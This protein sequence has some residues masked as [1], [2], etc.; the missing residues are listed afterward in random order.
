MEALYGDSNVEKKLGP[1]KVLEDQYNLDFTC[2]NRSSGPVKVQK[3]SQCLRHPATVL[4][5]SLS[6]VLANE[7]RRYMC[8]VFSHWLRPCLVIHRN[9]PQAPELQKTVHAWHHIIMPRPKHWTPDME[10]VLK[11]WQNGGNVYVNIFFLDQPILIQVQIE[12][13]GKK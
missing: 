2:G 1:V 6:K 5:L 12:K 7:R 3:F 10:F 9:C 11:R 4:Y 13:K 8:N